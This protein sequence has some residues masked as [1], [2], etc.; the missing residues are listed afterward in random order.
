MISIINF[1]IVYY[2]INDVY[3]CITNSSECYKIP[4]NHNSV[5][6]YNYATL[7]HIYHSAV[8]Q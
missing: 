4:W 1:I 5:K 6:V 3:T 8:C 2:A 7:L